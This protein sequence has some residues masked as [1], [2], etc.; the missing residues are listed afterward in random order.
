MANIDNQRSATHASAVRVG[1]RGVLIRGEPGAG[2]SSLALALLFGGPSDATLIADDRVILSA[3]NSRLAASV[4][5]PVAGLLEVRGVGIVRLPYVAEAW[6]DLVADLAPLA[7]C[8]RLP[9]ESEALV[10][11]GG[12]R[13]PRIFVAIGTPDGALRIRAAL[14]RLEA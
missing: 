14:T 6:I 2:K 4:P 8:P 3:D 11:I 1:S 10:E 5:E 9:D 7:A 13:I 12:I